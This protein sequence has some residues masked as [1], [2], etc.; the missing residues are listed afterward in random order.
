MERVIRLKRWAIYGAVLAVVAV[1]VFY[2]LSTGTEEDADL[3]GKEGGPEPFVQF[4]PM[5]QD[6][7][8]MGQPAR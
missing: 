3:H 8:T 1:A 4:A 7:P 6:E 5:D 2:I